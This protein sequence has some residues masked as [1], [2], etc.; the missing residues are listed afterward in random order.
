MDLS[1]EKLNCLKAKEID[2]VQYLSSLGYEPLK[3]REHNY[4]YLSPFRNERT[5]SFKVNRKINAWYDFGEAIGGNLIDF[6]M[7][8][9][10]CDVSGFLK[11]LRDGHSIITFLRSPVE[12]LVKELAE[13]KINIINETSIHSNSL[14]QYLTRR[15]IN[16]NVARQYCSEITY[17]INDR[18]HIA[19]GFKNIAGGYELRSPS[20]K[21]SSTPKD[22]T[23]LNWGSTKVAVYEG[24]FDLLSFISSNKNTITEDALVLNSVAFFDRAQPLLHSYKKKLLR[25]DNDPA[26]DKTTTVALAVSDA[27]MDDRKW[28]AGYKD[29]NDWLVNSS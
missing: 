15:A 16:I 7:R 18:E 12:V 22:I 9:F 24:F 14:L 1:E 27:Y 28:Y 3:I 8:Y 11:I 13:P 19:I 25:L 4:W 10:G 29:I 23:I 20:F 17:L 2:M 5:A 26:G 6:G 21:G